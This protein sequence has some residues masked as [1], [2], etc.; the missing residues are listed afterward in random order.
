[1]VGFRL[2]LLSVCQRRSGPEPVAADESIPGII[3]DAAE[4]TGR[5]RSDFDVQEIRRKR[6]EQ[7]KRFLFAK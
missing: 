2:L 1:V 6:C 7:L 5:P 3:A 4:E